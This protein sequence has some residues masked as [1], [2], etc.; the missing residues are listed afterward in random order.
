MI[1]FYGGCCVFYDPVSEYMEIIFIQ[2]GHQEAE[3]HS[4]SD[5]SLCV[6]DS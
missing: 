6:S 2:E 5:T 4:E 1:E 3:E